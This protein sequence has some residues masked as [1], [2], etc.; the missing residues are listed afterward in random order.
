MCVCVY[1]YVC[2]LTIHLYNTTTIYIVSVPNVF[3]YTQTPPDSRT[4]CSQNVCVLFH[5]V[6]MYRDESLPNIPQGNDTQSSWK[7][8]MLTK[9]TQNINNNS[10]IGFG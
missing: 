6:W 7:L 1:V 4:R 8:S 2:V 9:K 5:V 10:N 3:S